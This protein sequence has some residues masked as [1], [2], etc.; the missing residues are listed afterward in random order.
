[1]IYLGCA[2]KSLLYRII[3]CYVTFKPFDAPEAFLPILIIPAKEGFHE[4]QALLVPVDATQAV[5]FFG[6]EIGKVGT[7]KTCTSGNYYHS[8]KICIPWK[9]GG[10]WQLIQQGWYRVFTAL[11]ICGKP[12]ETFLPANLLTLLK[13]Q[14][15][16]YG[17]LCYPNR[18]F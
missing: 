5:V 6:E 7:Y 3:I 1:M 2:C 11:N 16:R 14:M 13:I 15:I 17:T 4:S 10:S 12:S 18:E 8:T 9:P